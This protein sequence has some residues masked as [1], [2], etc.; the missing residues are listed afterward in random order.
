MGF[1]YLGAYLVYG[2]ELSDEESVQFFQQIEHDTENH[3]TSNIFIKHYGI[4]D[5]EKYFIYW[6]CCFRGGGMWNLSFIRS[7]DNISNKINIDQMKI[8]EDSFDEFQMKEFCKKYDILYKNPQWQT[9]V[10]CG[11]CIY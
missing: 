5:F 11:Q 7:T 1:G 4:D 6:K 9:L 8:I 2:I 10:C 3:E